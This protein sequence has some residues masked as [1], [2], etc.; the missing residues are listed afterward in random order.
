MTKSDEPYCV[1]CTGL[2][3]LYHLQYYIH[4]EGSAHRDSRAVDE[5]SETFYDEPVLI[6]TVVMKPTNKDSKSHFRQVTL[7]CGCINYVL[8]YYL[9]TQYYHTYDDIHCMNDTSKR[10]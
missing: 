1:P 7:Y 6:F 3:Q 9:G 10:A 2:E 8:F 5:L 4:M